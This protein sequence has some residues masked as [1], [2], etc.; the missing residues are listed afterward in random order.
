MPIKSAV[1]SFLSRCIALNLAA[2]SITWYR[3]ILK[4]LAAFL[5]ESEARELKEV[6]P[7]LLR[8]HLSGLRRRGH[9]SETVF[10]TYGGI[11]CAF[12]FWMREGMIARNPMELV[13]RPRR[14]RA[15]IRPMSPE[16]A[17]RLLDTPDARS[18]EGVRDRAMMMLMLDSGLRISE[19]LSLDSGRVDWLNCSAIV[20]G[21]GRKE[22]SVPFSARTAQ[23]LLE[24]ARARSQRPAKA[25]QFFLG[26]TGKPICRSK[27]RKLILRY[28]QQAGIEGVRLS[29]HTLRHTFAVLYVRNGGDSFSLQEILGHSTLEMT[30]QYVNLAR[31]DVAEQHKK[32]SPIDVLAGKTSAA[33]TVTQNYQLV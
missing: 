9:A 6:S 16:Q 23:A 20:M 18:W 7:A 21:K 2:G 1:E 15:L 33:S 17:T 3:H 14:E 10:R 5:A 32:F 27:M 28:G 31:R 25:A 12:R 19:V 11:R 8:D 24:Y 13:E 29:P 30:R 4:D 26:R 22:R